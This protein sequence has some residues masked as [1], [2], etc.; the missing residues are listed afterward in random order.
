MLRSDLTGSARFKFSLLPRSCVFKH[1]AMASPS[2]ASLS[3]AAAAPGVVAAEGKGKGKLNLHHQFWEEQ[4]NRSRLRRMQSVTEGEPG[5]PSAVPP[6]TEEEYPPCPRV[7]VGDEDEPPSRS[8]SGDSLGG[9]TLDGLQQAK[10]DQAEWD[11][12]HGAAMRLTQPG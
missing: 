4:G 1:I 2:G 3:L 7:Y 12:N 6:S 8:S 11:M 5:S 9:C 10:R